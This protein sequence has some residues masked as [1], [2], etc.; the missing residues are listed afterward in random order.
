M[1]K[2]IL[3]LLLMILTLSMFLLFG[4]E[5]TGNN[6]DRKVIVDNTIKIEALIPDNSTGELIESGI[7]FANNLANNIYFD[8]QISIEF[9]ATKYRNED[10]IAEIAQVIEA[11]GAS[12]IIYGGDNYSNFKSFTAFVESTNIPVISLC[13]FDF[14]SDNF[15]SLTL[16]PKYLSS[17][18]ATYAIENSIKNPLVVLEDTSDYYVGFAEI[19]TSTFLSYTG[20]EPHIIYSSS[21]D[22]YS[23]YFEHDF[24]FL[25]SSES[26]YAE[27]ITDLRSHGFTGEIMLSEVF[28]KS[29]VSGDLFNNCSLISKY[30]KDTSNN[31]STVFG[32][33][34]S[35]QH[36]IADD[37]ISPAVAYG[38]D[39]Y[40]IAFEALKNFE[41]KDDLLFGSVNTTED[42][43]SDVTSMDFLLSDY[44]R[45]IS[46][47]N[48]RGITDVISFDGNNVNP[49]CVY[50]DNVIG[51]KVFF[52]KKYTFTSDR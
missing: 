6:R 44:C 32:T 52:G 10:N 41:P 47:V 33:M 14:E 9:S 22:D 38:Y 39:A 30:E 27:I 15:F 23:L 16:T 12:A 2:R 28:D 37:N 45:V 7:A 8:E 25:S 18:G 24:I 40:M 26:T 48:Y 46:D 17:C 20:N 11:N 1:S 13:P 3:S 35:E 29:V 36:G 42:T 34:Y 21:L 49:T 5:I 50:V 43:A 51:D 31:V 4:C 19:I